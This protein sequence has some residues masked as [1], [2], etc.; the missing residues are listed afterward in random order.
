M[1]RIVLGVAYLAALL[2]GVTGAGI[3]W[4]RADWHWVV[5]WLLAAGLALLGVQLVI[6]GAE[7]ERLTAAIGLWRRQDPDAW[8]RDTTP[9]PID[10]GDDVEHLTT[11]L[12]GRVT[13]LQPNSAGTP[14]AWI[15]F[16]DPADPE[17]PADDEV[18]VPLAV[19]RH[20]PADQESAD[21]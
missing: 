13:E 12:L 17:A 19:L 7:I 2:A 1:T 5:T 11:R 14:G 15:A 16:A 9:R 3:A 10:V 6:Q 20:A 8:R 21:A 4:T 18:W